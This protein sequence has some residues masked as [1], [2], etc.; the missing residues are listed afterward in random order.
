MAKSD[1]E[2]VD[3]KSDILHE[4]TK[5]FVFGKDNVSEISV[6]LLNTKSEMRG[7]G[8]AAPQIGI[9]ISVFSFLD[10]VVFNPEILEESQILETVLE[11]CLSY[12]GIWIA[13]KRPIA[14]KVRYQTVTGDF[15]E[16]DLDGLEA[17]IFQ[18]EFDHLKGI[19]FT[20]T[21]SNL[22]LKRA[23]EKAVK[24][25]YTYKLKDLIGI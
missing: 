8:L 2:L 3:F 18:H 1:A 13:V 14:I 9:D 6:K 20:D 10:E 19:T 21:A 16:R 17:R 4:S 22:K 24:N 12:P 25:G 5:P 11:G 15:L 7:Y 23:I